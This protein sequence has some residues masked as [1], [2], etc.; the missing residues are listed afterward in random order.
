[1]NQIW[2][3]ILVEI[4]ITSNNGGQLDKCRVERDRFLTN[5]WVIKQLMSKDSP[6]CD[7]SYYDE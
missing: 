2:S 3:D 6:R 7:H 4:K 1:M 5:P